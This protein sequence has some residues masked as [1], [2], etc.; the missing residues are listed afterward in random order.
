MPK[1][2]DIQRILIVGSGPIVI[3]QGCEF[4][5]SGTQACRALREEGYDVILVNSNPATIMTDPETASR[6][7]V[8][9][10]TVPYLENIISK[11]RPQAMLP[12]MG[13]QTALNL[14][15]E[16]SRAG[17]LE[18]Y[19]VELIGANCRAIE[20]A[21]SRERFKEV[22]VA[23]EV[24]FPRSGL[25]HTVDEAKRV[26]VDV[27]FPCIIRPSFTLGGTG[28]SIAYNQEEFGPEVVRGLEAS[29]ISE[30]LI[31]ESV[32]GWKEFE[33]EVMR[34]RRDNVVIVCSIENI[35][36]MGVHT[37][38]SITVAPIQTLTD[39]E[40]QKMRDAA[41]RIIRGV[42]VDTGGSNI[43]FAVHPMTG[44]QVA[45]EMNPRVSR[46][47]ALASKATGF[48]I[49]KIAAKLAVGYTLDEI[50]NDITR[51]TPSCFEPS[52]DYVVTKVPRFAFDKFPRSDNTLSPSM[53][54]VGEA[55]AIGR[56]FEESLQKALRSLEAGYW[57]LVPIQERRSLRS[58]QTWIDG[59][60]SYV[61]LAKADRLLW[62]AQGLREGIELAEMA[63]LT[64]VD[65]W[66]LRR[67]AGIVAME[68][69]IGGWA[70]K[71]AEVDVATIRR[72]KQRGFS[73]AAIAYWMKS[74]EEQV[75]QKRLQL[76]VR[77]AYKMVDTCAAEFESSTPYLYSTYEATS[78]PLPE[79]T[80]R[81]VVILGGG[82][83]RIGQGIEFDYCCVHASMALREEGCES[84]MVNCNPETVSTDY[85]V[86]DRLYFEPLFLEEILGILDREQPSGVVVHFG[87]QTPL[88][89]SRQLASHHVPIIGTPAEAIAVAEDRDQF[90]ALCH[91]IQIGQPESVT[92]ARRDLAQEAAESLGYPLLV[93][94]SYVLGGVGME[95]LYNSRD[96]QRWMMRGVEVS[97]DS[98]LLIDRFLNRA[99]E[100]DVDAV[101]DGNDVVICGILEQI[102]EAG[103][104][105]GDSACSM[106]PMTLSPEIQGELERQT[107]LIALELKV[108]GLINIQYAIEGGKIYVLEVNPR[109]SRTVP[110]A[111]KARG[112][113][114]SKIAM[115]VMLGRKLAEFQVPPMPKGLYYVKES[116]FPFNRFPKTD[117]ILGPE[118]R[119]TGEVMGIGRT[120]AEAFGKAQLAAGV[121]LPFSGRAFLSVTDADKNDVLEVATRLRD[122]GFE[123]CATRGTQSFLAER[124]MTVSVV[125]KVNEGRP[126]IVDLI[127]SGEIQ[128][129]VNTSALGVHEVGAAYELRRNTLMRGIC[130]FTTITAARAGTQALAELK[131]V[132]VETFSLQER[133][134]R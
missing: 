36:P 77:P 67:V 107:R 60:R 28:A 88:N 31:E 56:T 113:P 126:H 45:I 23:A 8:E 110:F 48:P 46:S 70:G 47:S 5:Y 104:H 75:R 124:N 97:A 92:V 24:D 27:G 35:D 25:A 81:K 21:E 2:T 122:L 65:A 112:I 134:T 43:Q 42:G 54:S 55:M 29:P 16:L 89:L 40:Y 105:S 14:A 127:R 4:D 83:N 78:D 37:G 79:S 133:E 73:D 82:P 51:K 94:P 9:P 103:V 129:V 95:I 128:L 49:A 85:D 57:G 33:L 132:P 108:V 72:W 123:L 84:I 44:R 39:V 38:D 121:R 11:E 68:G 34:D 109:G 98:P 91:R 32:L 119:S 99:V 116:V 87:G 30:I 59:I 115:K 58:G 90:R 13:G 111:S 96:F 66:F 62:I 6:T 120:F 76:A 18:K 12:T 100:V 7:Y 53:K 93:R 19:G 131:R 69:E 1:R 3:G 26:A 130:Y 117:I 71:L 52:I 64:S 102:Q 61:K 20:L 118:M 125:N 80:R 15:M 41:I 74:S 22:L 63:Q 86:S 114:F 17:V 50:P 101:A 10:L 106:P